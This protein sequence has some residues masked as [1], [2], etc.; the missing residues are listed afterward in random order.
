MRISVPVYLK[1]TRSQMPAAIEIEI[2]PDDVIIFE[3][4]IA[5]SLAQHSKV[6]THQYAI[7]I[8]EDQRKARF[9]EEYRRRMLT[10][11]MAESLYQARVADEYEFVRKL[12]GGVRHLP[13]LTTGFAY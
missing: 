10:K 3:G 5:L 11:E 2:L 13:S 7:S 6:T 8:D 1:K 12:T 9:I 4:V